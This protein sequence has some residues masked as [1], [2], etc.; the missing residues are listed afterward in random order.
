MLANKEPLFCQSWSFELLNAISWFFAQIY[1]MWAW[2]SKYKAS[3]WGKNQKPGMEKVRGWGKTI[4]WEWKRGRG[5]DPRQGRLKSPAALMHFFCEDP[6]EIF[7]KMIRPVFTARGKILTV[8]QR[9]RQNFDH[10][11]PQEPY[12]DHFLPLETKF[13]P[14][15]TAEG[16]ILTGRLIGGPLGASWAGGLDANA[17]FTSLKSRPDPRLRYSPR[18]CSSK[19]KKVTYLL[20]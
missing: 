1:Q 6:S 15:F 13:W 9:R 7:V 12:I 16:I 14:Y 5:W 10:I 18:N 8:F 20:P 17:S 2:F 11:L 19:S 3:Q 4:R